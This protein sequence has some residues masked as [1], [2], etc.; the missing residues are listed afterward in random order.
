M[1]KNDFAVGDE[2]DQSL[3]EYKNSRS[4]ITTE[5][6]ED[7]KRYLPFSVVDV[8][9]ANQN[10]KSIATPDS[11]ESDCVYKAVASSELRFDSANQVR[12]Q[13]ANY[14]THNSDLG[15][16]FSNLYVRTSGV[17][18]HIKLLPYL[19]NFLQKKIVLHSS[20][21]GDPISIPCNSSKTNASLDLHIET[22]KAEGIGHVELYSPD[23]TEQ[24]CNDTQVNQ[25]V[26]F[27]CGLDNETEI[28]MSILTRLSR[29]FIKK[30]N[31]PFFN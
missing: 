21:A 7:I 28:K 14:L 15:R 25:K 20:G 16:L 11:W 29:Y 5:I 17:P 30:I 1:V 18:L 19:A 22:T 9:T 6:A 23:N 4:Y 8:Y 2:F 24:K 3:Y 12:R 27:C 13:F 10:N 31:T 26:S